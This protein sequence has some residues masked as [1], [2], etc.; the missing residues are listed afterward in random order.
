MYTYFSPESTVLIKTLDTEATMRC[1]LNLLR[2][3]PL[4]LLG[5]A[6]L[7]LHATD[8]NVLIADPGLTSTLTGSLTGGV[9]GFNIAVG[10]FDNGGAAV[11]CASCSL[12]FSTGALTGVVIATPGSGAAEFDFGPGGSFTI[13]G[14]SQDPIPIQVALLTGTFLGNTQLLSDP[15]SGWDLFA[16]GA[17]IETI[18]STDFPAGIAPVSTSFNTGAL[19]LF[20]STPLFINQRATN[21][22]PLCSETEVTCFSNL[23]NPDVPGSGSFTGVASF[24][25]V[26]EPSSFLLLGGG[27]VSLG[28]LARR[29]KRS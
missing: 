7:S 23:N 17:T 19:V 14:L 22:D 18:D 28:L 8:L 24:T 20:G 12:D 16:L 5:S 1:S 21:D 6:T 3:L 9:T 15:L 10:T 27:L 29:K 2:I 13:F 25:D 11:D 4:I 26:P